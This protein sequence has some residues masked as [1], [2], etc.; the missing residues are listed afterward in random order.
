MALEKKNIYEFSDYRSYL[1]YRESESKKG[2]RLALSRATKTTP[3]YITRFFSN[4][5][6]LGLEHGEAIN[7]ML[8]HSEEESHFFLLLISKERAGTTELKKYYQKQIDQ[9]IESRKNFTNRT[10]LNEGIQPADQAIYFSKWYYAAIHILTSIPEFQTKEMIA[11][12]LDLPMKI[13]NSALEL[14]TRVGLIAPNGNLFQITNKRIHI[15]K[16]SHWVDQKHTIIRNRAVFSL[17]NAQENDLHYSMELSISKKDFELMRSKILDLL[18]SF[19]KT[20]TDSKEEELYAL[21]IDL[22][23][24]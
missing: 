19:E 3:A 14:L 22:F 7:Q 11:K 21:G 23:R 12:R 17:T 1:A 5:V 2:F 8:Q 4:L 18:E 15:A 24:Y 13:V 6:E 9:I 16:N 20:I 10:K